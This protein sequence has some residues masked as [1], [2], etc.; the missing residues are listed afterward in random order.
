MQR[1][2]EAPTV[3]SGA[4]QGEIQGVL[5]P[6]DALEEAFPTWSDGI[7]DRPFGYSA[8]RPTSGQRSDVTSK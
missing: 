6:M 2:P 1:A 3:P 5:E 7:A 8:S 4:V